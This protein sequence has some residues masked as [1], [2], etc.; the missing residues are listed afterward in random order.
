MDGRDKMKVVNA[1][2]K[3][4]RS[5]A[6]A[7]LTEGIGI[8]R[9]NKIPID[10]YTPKISRMKIREPLIL[11]GDLA[12]KIDVEISV[13][14]GGFNSQVEAARVALA[15]AMVEFSKGSKLKET[16]LAYDRNFLVSD[17]RYK[18][19]HKPNRHGK[20]RGKVQKSYR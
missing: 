16:F 19:T 6:R 13:N 2:G 18:E 9:I 12:N 7:M 8:V 5:I 4:K 14:G 17:V 15:N 20:A 10:N 3:R 1:S 11:A